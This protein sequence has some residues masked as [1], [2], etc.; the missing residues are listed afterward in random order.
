MKTVFS[1]LLGLLLAFAP[2]AQAASPRQVLATPVIQKVAAVEGVTEYRLR[3]GLKVLL[4]PDRSIDSV[5]VNMV[6]LVGTR[7]EGYGQSGMAHLLEHLL[8]RG[9]RHIPNIKVELTRHGAHYNGTTSLDRTTYY[10]TFP[11]TTANLD[12]ALALEADRMVNAH[13]SRED[14]D[15]EMTVVRNEFEWGENSAFGVLRE[16]VTSTAYLWHNYG[17]AIIG[18]RSDIENVPISRVQ[19]FYREYYQPDN[20]V[21]V[22]SGRF[23]E[24][25]ALRLTAK[26]FARIPKPKRALVPTYTAEPTQDGERSVTLRRVG[27]VQM[28]SALYHMPAG[29]H[30]DYAAIDVL[31]S[32]LSQVPGG[33][34]HKALVETGMA[35]SVFGSENQQREAGSAYFS[36]S[37]RQD[38]SLEAA[39]DA[40]LATLEGFAR[41]PVKE[42]E[43]ERARTRLTNDIE[44]TIADSRSLA[45]T[46]SESIAMG[47]WRTLFLHRDRLKTV[48]PA[49]VQRVAT[50]YL[51][52][53]NRTL[54]LF[55]PTREPDRAE[56]P[57]VPDVA[58][59]VKDY[60]GAGPIAV[61]EA[62][63]P[64]PANI[65]ARVIRRTLP[66]GMKL[67][68]LPKKTRGGTVVAQLSLRWGN[69]E[70]KAGR[71]TACGIASTMLLRGSRN[72]TREQVA[73]EFARIKS[74]VDIGGDGGSIETLREYLPAALRLVAEVLRHPAFPE[75][76][77]EQ[78]RRSAL[79]R[80]DIQSGD[81]S[82]LSSLELSRHLNPYPK[83]HWFYR[84]SLQER[85]DRIK[86]LKLEDVKHCY[87]DLYGATNSELAIVGDFDPDEITRLA[88]ELF[89]DWRS[90]KPYQRIASR[91]HEAPPLKR[92]IET[93]D[94]ANASYRAGMNLRLRDDSPDYAALVLAN[95]LLGEGSDSRLVQRIRE[96]EGISYSVGSYL[97]A[98]SFDE[99]GSFGIYAIC[100]PQNRAR[101]ESLV[102]EELQ[103]AL[104]DGFSAEEV[105]VAKKSILQA[106]QVARTQDS[107]VAGR[108][109]HYLELDRTFAW[110][111]EQDKRIGAL[112]PAEVVAAMRRHIDPLRLSIVEAGDFANNV[113]SNAKGAARN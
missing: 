71:S 34:L 90:P 99:R 17:S 8:F 64:T 83:E 70:A 86:A 33:R 29:T 55:L 48:T 58:T 21:L 22:I 50:T 66:G 38:R 4:V 84:A 92:V 75:S 9:T 103:K 94:K 31:V 88:I 69:E 113:A 37:V 61:G 59:M 25:I 45:L 14:L 105:A 102:R 32:L 2:P 19:A 53:S 85:A 87:A 60:R 47:D 93:P 96:R 80:I 100:A 13:V 82:A 41:N 95:R 68:L 89:G 62:F 72:K 18:A 1:A 46:L 15:A 74:Q 43:V 10:E 39:R 35:S 109:V 7:N 91:Y 52:T 24:A 77:F 101:L 16:R 108:L 98:N 78:L 28:V 30:E 63:E 3:N 110:D 40:L 20:A 107:S 73:N 51:K 112:T 104:D 106:R 49:D 27:D 26:H 79:T 81:P 54:G 11:A 76:E 12:W 42:E 65:E 56:I 36:A 57:P 97:S 5:T 67:A 111:A 6:Y 23:D 44:M